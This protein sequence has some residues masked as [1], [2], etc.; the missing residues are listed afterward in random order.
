MMLRK[1]L[2]FLVLV[3]ALLIPATAVYAVVDSVTLYD[4]S[5]PVHQVDLLTTEVDG[6]NV[7][8][9]YAITGLSDVPFALSHW[10]LAIDTCISEEFLVSPADGSTYDTPTDL[11]ECEDDYDCEPASYDVTAGFDGSTGMTGLKFDIIGEEGLNEGETHIFEITVKDVLGD[12]DVNLLTKYGDT[13]TGGDEEITGPV[14]PGPT[15]VTF[16]SSNVSSQAT[17]ALLPFVLLM[18]LGLA[19]VSVVVWRRQVTTG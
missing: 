3:L 2:Y 11:D 10:V 7:T 16:S 17:S 8:Y 13:D 5:D 12:E 14:C 19:T 15:A 18:G 4:G 1:K 6:A 9:T